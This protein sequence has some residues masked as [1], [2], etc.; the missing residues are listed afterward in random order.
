M[1]RTVFS[2]N[3]PSDPFRIRRDGNHQNGGI[4]PIVSDSGWA[5]DVTLLQLLEKNQGQSLMTFIGRFG[6]SVALSPSLRVHRENYTILSFRWMSASHNGVETPI[7]CVLYDG[8]PRRIVAAYSKVDK[9]KS[10][11]LNVAEVMIHQRGVTPIGVHR[12]LGKVFEYSLELGISSIHRHNG[13]HLPWC[14]P[15]SVTYSRR[16]IIFVPWPSFLSHL[17]MKL[18]H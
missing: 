17:I 1:R 8:I 6:L 9:T 10:R 16:L 11:S 2:A 15:K 5:S 18:P 4:H 12:R 13:S 7:W 14:L 3:K